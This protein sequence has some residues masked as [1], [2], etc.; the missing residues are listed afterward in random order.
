MLFKIDYTQLSDRSRKT[1][2]VNHAADKTE[3]VTRFM[4]W[5]F[6]AHPRDSVLPREVTEIEFIGDL[7]GID[8]I[9]GAVREA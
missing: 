6:R 4:D 5:F 2:F 1:K 7:S 9:D 3:A 8:L